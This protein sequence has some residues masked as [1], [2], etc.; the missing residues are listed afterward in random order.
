MFGR[1]RLVRYLRARFRS[2][3]AG[4][5]DSPLAQGQVETSQTGTAPAIYIRPD[6]GGPVR[7]TEILTNVIQRR[8]SL[9]SLK[10]E[11]PELEDVRHPFA[12]ILTQDCDLEQDF[13]D[14]KNTAAG[15]SADK[16]IPNVLL[17]EAVTSSELVAALPR[18]KDIRKRVL[19][20]KDERYH[21]FQKV[22][23]VD[24]AQGEGLPALGVD[25]KRYFTVPTDELYAQLDSN[26]KR[27]AHFRSPYLEHFVKR[28]A[29]FQSRVALPKEHE[30]Q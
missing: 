26:A 3:T 15:W 20:N 24:D 18:G 16:L 25:F 9:R 1:S 11:K 30:I 5:K 29:D 21:V 19:Q 6:T 14:R 17:S 27:R 23:A 22:E 10:A 13:I 2:A 28:F 4:S 8:R 7:Q 12:V